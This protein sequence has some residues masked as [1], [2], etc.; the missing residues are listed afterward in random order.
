MIMELRDGTTKQL[1]L[2]QPLSDAMMSHRSL[3]RSVRPDNRLCLTASEDIV[4]TIPRWR[5]SIEVFI[6]KDDYFIEA[7]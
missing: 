5:G 6:W 4:M 3:R 2:T 1:R 7:K